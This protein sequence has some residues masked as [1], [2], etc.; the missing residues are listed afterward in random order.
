MGIIHVDPGYGRGLTASDGEITYV[1]SDEY[2]PVNGVAF[3]CFAS[4]S[5]APTVN[6]PLP[7]DLPSY[8]A[9]N[10]SHWI[11]FR[12]SAYLNIKSSNYLTAGFGPRSRITLSNN[13]AIAYMAVDTN[14]SSFTSQELATPLASGFHNVAL[15]MFVKRVNQYYY[16]Y[17]YA[18]VDGDTWV[19]TSTES[20]SDSTFGITHIFS[21]G[22]RFAFPALT[23]D[24]GYIS[25]IIVAHQVTTRGNLTGNHLLAKLPLSSP[26][27]TDFLSAG[28]G[29]YVGA[30]SGQK[31]L[32]AINAGENSDVITKFGA[33]SKVSHIIT[34]GNPGYRV[35]SNITSATGISQSG[36]DSIT[37][38]GNCSLSADA[39]AAACVAWEAPEGTK[40]SDLD[41]LKVGWQV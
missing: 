6:L 27:T 40:L 33:T 19:N 29:E 21:D 8:L 34:Y 32:S 17:L 16:I 25:N 36:N 28:D 26:P 38:H 24:I 37:A 2:N 20:Y 5:T 1:E 39:D 22:I 18:D 35:G 23:T 10:Q 13:R 31:L 14:T 3:R 9:N 4:G 11:G 15:S 7:A 30:T 41:G 12:F